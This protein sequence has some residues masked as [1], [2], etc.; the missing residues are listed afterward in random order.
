MDDV[1]RE[2]GVSKKT[3]YKHVSN[4]AQL[5]DV[6]VKNMFEKVTLMLKSFSQ[7]TDNAIDELFALDAYF[8]EMTKQN[9]PAIMYQLSKHYPNTFKWLNDAKAKFIYETTK[10][11]LEKGLRQELYRKELNISYV[12]YIYMAHTDLLEDSN[13]PQEICESA[14]FH[15]HHMEYHIRGIASEKGL[16]YL[17]QKLNTK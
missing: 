5:I 17:N 13:V 2:L 4:K 3:L 11:N 10:T 14:D 6:G 1:A 16:N 8:D 15:K 9:H 7:N 12:S